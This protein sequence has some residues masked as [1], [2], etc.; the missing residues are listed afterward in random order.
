MIQTVIACVFAV[1]IYK[2]IVKRRGL[3]AS[4]L[5][6]YGVLIPLACWIPFPLLAY[7]QVQNKVLKMSFTTLPSIAAFRCVEAMHN[8]SPKAV[9]ASLANYVHYYSSLVNH[10]WNSNTNTR[11]RATTREVLGNAGM[12]FGQFILLSGVLSLLL[13]FQFKPFSSNVQLDQFHVTWELI[14]P[15]QLANNYLLA[16]LT[17]YSLAV[18]FNLMALMGNLQ[19]YAVRDFLRNPL[20]HS[21]SPS[22][23]WAKWNP[24]IGGALKASMIQV[25]V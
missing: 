18:G 12:I 20:F 11:V 22:D 10:V 13:A 21:K 4:F 16:V 14:H 19:G 7:L 23:F 8:T 5:L 24:V 2:Y 15:G 6:G 17:L 1:I 25:I 3:P 9:E